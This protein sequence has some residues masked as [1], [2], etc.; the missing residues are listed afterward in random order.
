MVNVIT[1]AAIRNY[2]AHACPGDKN[3]KIYFSFIYDSGKLWQLC[4]LEIGIDCNTA[5][6]TYNKHPTMFR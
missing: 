3:I 6:A 5:V 2:I 1:T 4:M